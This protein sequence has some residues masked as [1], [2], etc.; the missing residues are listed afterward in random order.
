[1]GYAPPK[2]TEKV[3]LDAIDKVIASS[4]KHGKKVGILAVDGE[5][6]KEIK[7][8]FDMIVMSADIRSL[9]AWYKRELEIAR[10]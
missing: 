7:N 10:S 2:F 4:K 9:Q 8:R 6:T 5:K 3:F 1:M